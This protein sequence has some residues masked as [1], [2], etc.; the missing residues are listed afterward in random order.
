MAILPTVASDFQFLFP[1]TDKGQERFHWFLLT[2]KAILVPITVSRTSNLLRAIETL[3]GVSIAQWRYYTFMASV[4]LPWDG[5][6]E[7]LW[8]AIP[9]PLVAGRLLVGLDD[10]INPKTGKKML[11]AE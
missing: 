3:F 5:V 8:R 4:K 10:S 6:W 7:A 1:L 2:L 9:S 11:P